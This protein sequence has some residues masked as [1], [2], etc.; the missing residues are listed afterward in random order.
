MTYAL[1]EGLTLLEGQRVRFGNDRDNVDDLRELLENDNV[2][3]L[4]P[5]TERMR[6]KNL[7]HKD[8][9]RMARG[10]DEEETAVYTR[11]GNVAVA[12][13]GE[14]LAEISRVLV[15]DVLDDGLPAVYGNQWIHQIK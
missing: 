2:N 3:G 11:V 9:L 5:N 6:K 1:S 15:L 7:D 13:C 8:G 4:E 10:G 14:F 12:L